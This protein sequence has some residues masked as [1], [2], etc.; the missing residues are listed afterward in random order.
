M[1]PLP[2]VQPS[3]LAD[4]TRCLVTLGNNVYDVTA[5]LP[6]HPGGSDLIEAFRGKDVKVMMADE[7][8]HDHSDAAYEIL[9]EFLIGYL[10]SSKPASLADSATTISPETYATGM[11][12]EEDLNVPT[13]IAVDYAC[14]KFLDLSRPLLPQVFCGGFT[15]A[16]YMEQVHRPRHYPYGSALLMP[17]AWMEPFSRTPWWVVPTLWIPG[18]AYGTYIASQGLSTLYQPHLFSLG[19]CFPYTFVFVLTD[20]FF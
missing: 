9:S 17:Y 20:V 19:F 14:H 8:S 11:S 12:C 3:D 15:K 6:D 5:F 10:V 2:T 13:N 18:V 4:R 7:P 1:Q 16:F